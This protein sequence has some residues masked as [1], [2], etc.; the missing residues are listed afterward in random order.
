M[1]LFHGYN[2]SAQLQDAVKLVAT[3]L[4]TLVT[5]GKTLTP[6]PAS[7]RETT[8]WDSGQT[9]FKWVHVC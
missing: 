7:C 9:L 3:A 2:E 5:A 4:N 6:P 1:E 8:Q